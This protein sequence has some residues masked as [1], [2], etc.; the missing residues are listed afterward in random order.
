MKAMRVAKRDQFKLHAVT[1]RDDVCLAMVEAGG[2]CAPRNDGKARR[3][4]RAM[5]PGTKVAKSVI[6]WGASLLT[7][8][9]RDQ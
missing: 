8:Y 9:P 7:T 1:Y 5:M 3:K 2:L 6:Y 4:S